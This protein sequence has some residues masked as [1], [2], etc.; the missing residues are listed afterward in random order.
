MARSPRR[1][2]ALW[3]LAAAAMLAAATCPD[4]S[5]L[6]ALVGLALWTGARGV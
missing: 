3:A 2:L 5:G 4:L 6:Y 1:Y